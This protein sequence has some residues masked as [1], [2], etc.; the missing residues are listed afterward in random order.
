MLINWD[1][2]LD[3]NSTSIKLKI[4][5]WYLNF[6]KLN[7]DRW[8]FFAQYDMKLDGVGLNAHMFCI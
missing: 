3:I 4:L 1:F 5:M 2:K 6:Q 7:M 8:W